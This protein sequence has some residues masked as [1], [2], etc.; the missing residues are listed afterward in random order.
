MSS[1]RFDPSL[2]LGEGEALQVLGRFKPKSDA[3]VVCEQ[4]GGREKGGRERKRTGYRPMV[5]SFLTISFMQSFKPTYYRRIS[6]S[7]FSFLLYR[8][9]FPSPPGNFVKVLVVKATQQIV[10]QALV[11]LAC[12]GAVDGKLRGVPSKAL[13]SMNMGTT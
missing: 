1:Y 9:P 7:P 8:F 10:A 12:I 5:A 4:V 11:T 2:R 6:S 3:I 13:E